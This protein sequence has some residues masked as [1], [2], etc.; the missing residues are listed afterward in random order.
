[1]AAGGYLCF[2]VGHYCKHSRDAL[3]LHASL[4]MQSLRVEHQMDEA[5]GAYLLFGFLNAQIRNLEIILDSL[6][7]L[8]IPCSLIITP[9]HFNLL[10]SKMSPHP[11]HLCLVQDLIPFDLNSQESR[12]CFHCP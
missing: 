1:M 7:S 10:T 3:S 12:D 6:L 11:Y 9:L 4:Q 8:Y 2:S 5:L